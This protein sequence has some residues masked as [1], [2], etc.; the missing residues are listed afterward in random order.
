MLSFTKNDYIL[1]FQFFCLSITLVRAF[2]KL[3]KIFQNIFPLISLQNAQKLLF[4]TK[5]A[6]KL[7][8]KQNLFWSGAKICKLY[9]KNKISKQFY[10]V[11]N[12][13]K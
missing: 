9:N 10:G 11:T 2:H 4:I 5:A 6:Q 13:A 8:E 1:I 12:E 3:L 7:L